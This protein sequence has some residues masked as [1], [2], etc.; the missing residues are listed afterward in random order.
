M[1]QFENS[2][3]RF[4]FFQQMKVTVAKPIYVTCLTLDRDIECQQALN[5]F[6]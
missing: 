4:V 3:A 2:N 5:A 1:K 6:S